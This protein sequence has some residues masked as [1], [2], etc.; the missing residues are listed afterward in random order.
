MVVNEKKILSKMRSPFVL[1]LKYAFHNEKN[2]YLV[3]D[4]CSGGDLK[5][6]LR[7]GK[8]GIRCIRCIRCVRLWVWAFRSETHFLF[9]LFCCGVVARI[10]A[11]GCSRPCS[12]LP[13]LIPITH[14]LILINHRTSSS[15]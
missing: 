8:V 7:I 6:H 2:L 10:R 11:G 13:Q 3:M 15:L 4:M 1:G 9:L 5:F 12:P 14:P